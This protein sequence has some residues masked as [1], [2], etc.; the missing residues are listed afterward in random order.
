MSKTFQIRIY[1]HPDKKKS[2]ID[3]HEVLYRQQTLAQIKRDFCQNTDVI[4]FLGEE[5]VTKSKWSKTRVKGG[6]KVT[7]VPAVGIVPVVA[8]YALVGQFLTSF[9]AGMFF[10]FI[11]GVLFGQGAKESK[12]AGTH[13]NYGWDPMTLQQE[14]V[15]RPRAYGKNCHVG[16][17]IACWTDVRAGTATQWV[18]FGWGDM[19]RRIFGIT[20]GDADPLEEK[21]AEILYLLVDYG[22][23]P[24]KGVVA[25]G[26]FI[27]DQPLS[28]Y[29]GAT[30]QERKGTLNQT[31]M[32]GFEKT[33]I[34]YAL[35]TTITYT[36]AAIVFTTPNIFADDLEYTVGFPNGVWK[37][38]DSGNKHY[39]TLGYKVEISEHGA[40]SWTVLFNDS[41]YSKT[42]S[43]IFKAYKVSEQGYTVAN[44][45][46]YDLRFTKTTEDKSQDRYGDTLVLRSVREVI[47]VA[48]THPGHVL[49]GLTAVATSQ[50]N[51]G[52]NL[53]CIREDR[54]IN[55][56]NGSAWVLQYSRNRAWGTLD[57]LTQPIL[58]GDGN[59]VSYAI[60]R[61]EGTDPTQID[62][63]FFYEW[64]DWC[65]AQVPSGITGSGATEDRMPCDIILDTQT[66]VFGQANDIAQVGR[67]HLYWQGNVITGW[68]DK[69]EVDDTDL[70]SMDNIMAASWTNSWMGQEELAGAVELFYQ[71]SVLGY[72]RKS[73]IYSNEAAG[74]YVRSISVE[75]IGITGRSLATRVAAFML[76]RNELIKNING[77][78]KYK[79]AMRY[80]LGDVVRI[81]A[82]TPKW[83]ASYQVL[84]V[85]STSVV[86][87]DRTV[88]ASENDLLY[89]RCYDDASGVQ[90]VAVKVYTVDSVSAKQVTIKETFDITPVKNWSV[91]I[92]STGEIKRRRIVKIT[93]APD[94]FY[95]I[96]VETY[97]ETLFDTDVTQEDHPYPNYIRAVPPNPLLTPITREAVVE[98]INKM[99]TPAPSIDIPWMSNIEWGVDSGG[100]ISWMARDATKPLL[101][102]FRGEDY[103]IVAGVATNEFAYWD[104]YAPEQFNG[105]DDAIIAV[106]DGC[107]LMCVAKNGIAYPATPIQLLHAGIIMAGTIVTDHLIVNCVTT[108]KV[109]DE[110]THNGGSS[111]SASDL[112][113]TTDYQDVTS[114]V[115]NSDG[116]PVEVTGV[117]Y[118]RNTGLVFAI[119]VLPRII[120]A[121]SG[122]VIAALS[123]SVS[124]NSS[125]VINFS[126]YCDIPAVGSI[127]Y[128]MQV[129]AAY[130][131]VCYADMGTTLLIKQ[132]KGK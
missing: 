123:C 26:I 46:Q 11:G 70:V 21:T 82:K 64:A 20:S 8:A 12:D 48:F 53:K 102:R 23:G 90:N 14:G 111:M 33:K 115:V 5:K 55:T 116:E 34:E 7:I 79:D 86:E 68:I 41:Y 59:T 69:E 131:D 42:M 35:G 95:D 27:N 99:S 107:W 24:T 62:L 37:F 51:S 97:D 25:D 73:L 32:T 81:Q 77:F 60:E 109:A 85:I 94:G 36:D 117:V 96:I 127:T 45:K 122:D 125:Q 93:E 63:A 18:Y 105:T 2:A 92:G 110:T 13:S 54:I 114:F 16:N 4:I 78:K 38:S 3:L 28:N 119:N 52:I 15:A 31:C 120:N 108:P 100:T 17:V 39:N 43:P 44:G 101:F 57:V 65:D 49:L 132:W 76:K 29:P 83:G 1:K 130:A 89:I 75:G 128:K 118:A 9:V 129:K 40:N 103:E 22:D 58:S 124:Q 71:D 72:E 88:I 113:L 104:P 126:T 80:K 74:N 56:Y 91:A 84:S 106:S 61:Y 87:L 10:S 47:N 98:L 112:E 121:T 30:Y 19:F 66:D 67:C 6:S 50:L